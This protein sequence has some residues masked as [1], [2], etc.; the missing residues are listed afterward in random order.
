LN[1][2]GKT[3]N[4]I[5]VNTV[6]ADLPLQI[7]DS[8][9]SASSINLGGLNSYGTT[10][11]IL[12]VNPTG[13][14]LEYT[15]T[16][17]GDVT[18]TS[19][20]SALRYVKAVSP[21]VINRLE[22]NN[23]SPN[24]RLLVYNLEN[25][26]SRQD[27]LIID[28]ATDDLLKIGNS[29]DTL[30]LI[31]A[32]Q[33][34]TLPTSAGTLALS[35]EIPT[36]NTE[37]SNGAGYITI[38]SVP[39]DNTELSN[40][41]GYITGS[42]PT[43]TSPTI[44]GTGSITASSFSGNLSGNVT[45][46]LTG[47]VFSANNTSLLSY[48]DNSPGVSR[49]ELNNT[50]TD[51]LFIYNLEFAY[52]RQNRVVISNATDNLLKIG[53]ATD[54]LQLINAGQ[55]ITLPTS[56]GTLALTSQIPTDNTELSNGAGY[57]TIA[58]VPTDNT[59]LSNGAGYITGSSPTITSPTITGT[60][61]ITASSFTGSLSGNV[62]GNVSGNLTG[63]VFSSNN[64][65]LL[66]YT[67]NSP[68]ISRCELNNTLSTDRLLIYNLEN[69]YSR[70]NKL[71]FKNTTDNEIEYG[72]SFDLFKLNHNGFQL[73]DPSGNIMLSNQ[74]NTATSRYNTVV[75]TGADNNE[76]VAL[77]I[78]NKSGASSGDCR[79]RLRNT[80]TTSTGSNAVI[81][82]LQNTGSGYEG[83]Y[84]YQV[85]SSYDLLLQSS[86]NIGF[87]DNDS[88]TAYFRNQSLL[89]QD[90]TSDIY[91]NITTPAHP[92]TSVARMRD[93]YCFE[94]FCEEIKSRDTILAN[95]AFKSI[96][97]YDSIE[98]VSV[99]APSATRAAYLEL[100]TDQEFTNPDDGV[101]P[102]SRVNAPSTS[103]QWY[104]FI[105]DNTDG[106]VYYG[107][108]WDEGVFTDYFLEFGSQSDTTIYGDVQMTLDLD[109]AGNLSK[110]TG[111]FKIKHPV[112]E[113]A[114]KDKYLIHSFVEAPRCDNIYSGR[115]RLQN[116]E[117]VVNLDAN[118]WYRMTP[119]TFNKLNKDLRVYV[120]NNE[121]FDRVIGQID[122]NQLNILC[123]NPNSS[124]VI[125][126][127]VIGTRQDD[128]VKESSI[129]DEDG[130]LITERIQ[131]PNKEKERKIRQNKRNKENRQQNIRDSKARSRFKGLT[132]RFQ[133]KT[134]KD[135]AL[136]TAKRLMQKRKK[137]SS[138]LKSQ[139]FDKDVQKATRR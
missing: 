30:Q 15:S 45:G 51:R 14:G 12:Q 116:G 47:S 23:S 37:L 46:N 74:L 91:G 121:N 83:S 132:K 123:E 82:L 70:Q 139:D 63:N 99:T 129:T 57:I 114:K 73:K 5:Y 40:G 85:A 128:Q 66:S 28:N 92:Q 61:S 71:I 56:T 19:N 27:R 50:G 106:E 11:Q 94:I 133:Q 108:F 35:S 59:E 113:E 90:S 96:Y 9:S 111:T 48:T 107:W 44:T 4:N 54:T 3:T 104:N 124:A 136:H 29:I 110:G 88:V 135:N 84:I 103:G 93:I 38:A 64:T 112:E 20:T 77:T 33:T 102:V 26:F 87:F 8:G 68:G 131:V 130:N 25:L 17:T 67:N 137:K 52:S 49:M 119:G 7:A 39:T 16:F 78:R 75:G 89:F 22:L 36:D 122:G 80:D 109:I 53:N 115:V 58:S 31:N 21:N 41:A 18:T 1:Q 72:N 69:M 24:D 10:K 101:Y 34:I 127:Q 100:G 13:D 120:C 81:E 97:P 6:T 86:R 60:G 62:T 95:K 134:R 126:W 55:T 2:G 65:S 43:I 76:N 125:D 32:G 42:S 117:A 138:S 118:D 79:L 98:P 105:Q